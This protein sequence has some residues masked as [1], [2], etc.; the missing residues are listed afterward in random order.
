MLNAR[1]STQQSIQHFIGIL[2]VIES[3]NYLEK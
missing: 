3:S 1:A 2:D